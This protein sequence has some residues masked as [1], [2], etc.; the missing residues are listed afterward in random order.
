MLTWF[1]FQKGPFTQLVV[2]INNLT[3]KSVG[4]MVRVYGR[5]NDQ[6]WQMLKLT[7]G[8]ALTTDLGTLNNCKGSNKERSPVRFEMSNH[9]LP[10]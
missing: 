8:Q 3:T 6:A 5:L 9:L 4:D 1:S 7:A 10:S 2:I